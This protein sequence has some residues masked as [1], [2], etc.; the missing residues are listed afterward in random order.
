M[1]ELKVFNELFEGGHKA[2][3]SVSIYQ[4][5]AK[6]EVDYFLNEQGIGSPSFVLINF[7]P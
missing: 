6:S 2:F 5:Q 4:H 3:K 7:Y 1:R